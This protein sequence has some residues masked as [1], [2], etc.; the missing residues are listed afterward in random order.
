MSVNPFLEKH[1]EKAKENEDAH[2]WNNAE[3][4]FRK[5][6]TQYLENEDY[7][8]AGETQ[9]KAAY[10][11]YRAAYQSEQVDE[12]KKRL[13]QVSDAFNQG[14]IIYEKLDG[15]LREARTKTNKIM[16][17]FFRSW[18]IEDPVKKKNG[19]AK[20]VDDFK[21]ALEIC[22]TE[23]ESRYG[24]VIN[25][26]LA[27]LHSISELSYN[28]VESLEVIE[29]AL[30]YGSQ[31]LDILKNRDEYELAR[32]YY[33]LSLFLPEVS[34]VFESTD[35]QQELLQTGKDYATKAV[36]LAEKVDDKYLTAMSYGILS[37]YVCE[38]DD[39]TEK[40][41]SLAKKQ[42]EIGEEIKDRLVQA[43]G[44]EFLSYYI[45]IKSGML[46][47]RDDVTSAV[48][49]EMEHADEA[50]KN[51]MIVLHPVII[52]FIARSN[53]PYILASFSTE[54][55][56]K[57]KYILMSIETSETDLEYARRTG[58][59]VG[60]MYLHMLLGASY[61]YFAKIERDENKK[62]DLF[63][64]S[65]R[66]REKYIE[67][68]VEIQ[69]FRNWNIAVAYID[70]ADLKAN[71]ADSESD[72]QRQTELMDE[73]AEDIDKSIELFNQY[74]KT[75]D[76]ASYRDNYAVGELR[77][78]EIYF[79][80]FLK[81]NKE[82]FLEKTITHFKNSI[83]S[84]KRQNMPSFIAELLW[85]SAWA[86]Y[87]TREYQQ[88]VIEFDSASRYYLLAAEKYPNFKKFYV[89]YGH[90]MEAWGNIARAMD[91]H[92][93]EEYFLEKEYFDKAVRLLSSSERWE[94][95]SP[96][97]SAWSKLA[98]A[99]NQSR[100]ENCEKAI[101][102][103][104]EASEYFEQAK[105]S[106]RDELGSIGMTD[107]VSMAT[108][109]ISASGLRR[110]YCQGRIAIEE[111]KL[112]DRK[113][114]YHAS[115]RRYGDAA[116]LFSKIID[117]MYNESEQR[118]IRP[119]YS[120]C[121]AWQKMALAEAEVSSE[122]YVEAGD[123][124]DKS[125]DES[126]N[127]KTR[128]LIS[129]H[130]NFC[131][132]LSAG[133]LYEDSR[134]EQHHQ[135]LV[136][137]LGSATDFYV[138]AGYDSAL[139]YSRATQRLFEAYQYIDRARTASDLGEKARFFGAAERLL[140]VSAEAFQR[141]NHPEKRDEV[142]RLLRSLREDREI[143]VSLSELLDTPGISS[144]TESFRAPTPSHEYPVG[145][146]SFEHSDIQVK[147]FLPDDTVTSGEEFNLE[148][149]FYNPGKSSASLVRVE[150]LVPDDFEVSSVSG[151]Y[152][153]DDDVLDL[154]GKRI[155]PLSTVEF[156]LRGRPH[157]KGE[158]TLEPRV[159]F[160]DDTGEQR[161][162]HPEPGII[163]VRDMGILSWLRGSDR[164]S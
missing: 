29:T 73:A 153:F 63:N 72:P 154:R 74:F 41:I 33:L 36:Q 37:Y 108:E 57:I 75:Y 134:G 102:F 150:G 27:I 142:V 104:N 21:E 46:E 116:Q 39:E 103:L 115:S 12:F 6:I 17:N 52:S 3:I 124:F 68:A 111:A 38:V 113:G 26:F 58:S 7:L 144:S 87:R 13:K 82:T 48:N 53:G 93:K 25:D 35:R 83:E 20:C 130:A 79:R 91:Y 9:E 152:R 14:V 159:V 94:Y 131:R 65:L 143:A 30:D 78:G 23:E 114:E 55:Q 85:K 120:L 22:E 126:R 77:F 45:D 69:P 42:L 40:A 139:D 157:S 8:K 88:S 80:M 47:D 161:F 121:L 43:R 28:H 34:D 84:Y 133:I 44:N 149:E 127:T 129:G 24:K 105:R 101:D 162:S 1:L 81:S 122:L 49:E 148:L 118:E 76:L 151:M 132:A 164:P 141:A 128:L 98:Q 106:I 138:R 50:I 16:A 89:D 95:T 112:H 99:E 100:N 158:F 54:L 160:I 117:S 145:L 110:D 4:N 163:T 60:Q 31:A 119:L 11:L 155:G 64:E 109:L 70:L 15:P 156:S 140:R 107:E 137:Y 90:Y 19:I 123:L 97:Y 86:Y 66:H 146:E 59:M 96:N 10:C 61:L 125:K 71:F 62:L 5:A 56:Q 51:Y 18:I 32:S 135:E 92:L 67:L 136:R 147:M 2:E